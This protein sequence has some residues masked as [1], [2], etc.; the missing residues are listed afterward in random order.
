[1]T[2]MLFAALVTAIA[3]GVAGIAVAGSPAHEAKSKKQRPAKLKIARVD[4]QLS[5]P[6]GEVSN[7]ETV[8]CP[9]GYRVTGGSLSP[10]AN[11]IAVSAPTPGKQSWTG[12]VGNPASFT[13]HWSIDVICAKGGNKYMKVVSGG[14]FV[15]R[16]RAV[17]ARARQQYDEFKQAFQR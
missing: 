16:K 12:A 11:E 3:V 9:R 1:M 2:R 15:A 14:Q 13:A 8:P 5:T 7:L 4:R 6:S 17:T 10:G